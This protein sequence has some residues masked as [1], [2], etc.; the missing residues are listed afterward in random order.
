[1]NRNKTNRAELTLNSVLSRIHMNIWSVSVAYGVFTQ[2]SKL[3]ANV[4]KVHM[5]ML[6][7]C[8]IV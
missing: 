5:L 4:F 2:S 7:V 3:P 8:W 1:M 6:D